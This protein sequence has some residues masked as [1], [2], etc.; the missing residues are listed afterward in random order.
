MSTP[1]GNIKAAGVSGWGVGYGDFSSAR[2]LPR[3]SS[4]WLSCC[5]LSQ[6][7]GAFSGEFQ[8]NS[9]VQVALTQ[10]EL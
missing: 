9:P 4:G 3:L 2:A 10:Q 6:D 8:A 5:E 1:L 7:F